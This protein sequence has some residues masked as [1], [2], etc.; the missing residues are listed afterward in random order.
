MQ[1]YLDQLS[2]EEKWW[3]YLNK[4]IENDDILKTHLFYIIDSITMYNH[5]YFMC[6]RCKFHLV[7]NDHEYY[8]YNYTQNQL[9]TCDEYIIKNII[10]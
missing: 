5:C 10:E 2:F 7:V 3:K 1:T 6:S 9:P 8:D 4:Y